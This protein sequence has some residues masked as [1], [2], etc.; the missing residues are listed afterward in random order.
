MIIFSL[1]LFHKIT[2]I[3]KGIRYVFKKPLYSNSDSD[4]DYDNNCGPLADGYD[5]NNYKQCSSEENSIGN[6]NLFDCDHGDY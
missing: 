4:S 6:N 2:P 1:D 3:T 5:I